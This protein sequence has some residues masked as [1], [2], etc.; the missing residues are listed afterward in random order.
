M[1]AFAF[2]AVMAA[3]FV[4]TAVVFGQALME[5]ILDVPGLAQIARPLGPERPAALKQPAAYRSPLSRGALFD[6]VPIYFNS[7]PRHSTCRVRPSRGN[8]SGGSG[9]YRLARDQASAAPN[10]SI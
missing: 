2:L 5:V 7:S 10:R 8:D 3:S 1:L 4:T 9:F 6:E